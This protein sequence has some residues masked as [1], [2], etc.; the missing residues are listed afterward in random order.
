MK[1]YGGAEAYCGCLYF[2]S[3]GRVVIVLASTYRLQ[4]TVFVL[5]DLDCAVSFMDL[6]AVAGA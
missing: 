2:I 6:C 4:G 5:I 3:A 1:I